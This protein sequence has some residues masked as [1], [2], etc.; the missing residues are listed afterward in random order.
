MIYSYYRINIWYISTFFSISL[1]MPRMI[2]NS[3]GPTKTTIESILVPQ[4]RRRYYLDFVQFQKGGCRE[5]REARQ[6]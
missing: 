6:G 1:F 3:P 5:G 2:Y 4:T